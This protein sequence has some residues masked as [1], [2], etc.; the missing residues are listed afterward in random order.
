MEAFLQATYRWKCVCQNISRQFRVKA[1]HLASH[2]VMQGESLTLMNLPETD[3]DEELK[4]SLSKSI[5]FRG[6]VVGSTYFEAAVE[7]S[8]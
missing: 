6:L 2:T 7:S 1:A 8:V 3:L 4:Y 5:W